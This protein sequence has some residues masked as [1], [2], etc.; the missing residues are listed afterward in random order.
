MDGFDAGFLAA[1]IG[2]IVSFLSPCV[3]PLVPAYLSFVA[4]A[5]YDD[6]TTQGSDAGLIQ[7]RVAIGSLAFVA[8]FSTV[9]V[10]LGAT[11]GAIS[12]FL[13]THKVLLGQIAG[14]IIIIL[15][16]HYVGLLRFALLNRDVRLLPSFAPDARN[17]FVPR[18]AMPYVVGLAFAFG[19]TPCIGP[20]L[21]TILAIAASQ[22]S[23]GYGVSLLGVYSAGLG[24]PFIA[25]A[26]AV[27]RFIGFSAR[28]RRHMHKVEVVAGLLLI[29]T[30]VLMTLGSLELIAI[31]L[32][33]VFPWLAE[34]G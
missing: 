1:L 31:Y 7:K 14:G 11:A 30:G 26:L 10:M 9:F 4:G 27:Q 20:I 18:V 25:A 22:E 5:S 23:L 33:E 19:W 3:L 17:G 2:G 12:P 32:I 28:F 34:I 16:L 24:I 13:L 15:G 21:A 8:G 6:L 29:A